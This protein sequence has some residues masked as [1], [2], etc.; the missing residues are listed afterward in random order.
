MLFAG[1]EL[2]YAC[3]GLVLNLNK[4]FLLH[5]YLEFLC[6]ALN[7][8]KTLFP[9]IFTSYCIFMGRFFKKPKYALDFV[10]EGRLFNPYNQGVFMPP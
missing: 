10:S 3:G 4:V 6:K 7:L 2:F 8:V 5:S 9:L 1:F